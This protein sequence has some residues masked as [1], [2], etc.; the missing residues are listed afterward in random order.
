MTLGVNDDDEDCFFGERLR[1]VWRL[2]SGLGE[3]AV[4][5]QASGSWT[6]IG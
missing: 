5:F 2:C 3:T 1:K 4:N 6:I